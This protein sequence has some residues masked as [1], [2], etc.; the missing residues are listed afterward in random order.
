MVKWKNLSYL[1]STWELESNLSA[2]NKIMDF[3]QFT[4]AL[5]KDTRCLMSQQLQRHKILLEI[6]YNVKKRQKLGISQINDI[7]S[8]LYFQYTPRNQPIYKDRKLLRDY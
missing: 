8:Q 1:D 2:Q 5:D 6:E 3:R 7:K 4:R